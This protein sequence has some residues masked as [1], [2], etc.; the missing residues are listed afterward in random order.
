MATAAAAT[1]VPL[2][3]LTIPHALAADEFPGLIRFSSTAVAA[4]APGEA[5]TVHLDVTNRS[6]QRWYGT[7]STQDYPVGVAVE[8]RRSAEEPWVLIG[9]ALLPDDLPPDATGPKW[10]WRSQIPQ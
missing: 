1:A 8:G 6:T 10:R 7:C 9:E 3:P 4:L 2:V 5:T